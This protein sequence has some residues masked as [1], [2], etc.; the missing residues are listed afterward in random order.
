MYINIY[1]LYL[2][3]FIF[4]LFVFVFI[5]FYNIKIKRLCIQDIQVT[6]YKKKEDFFDTEGYL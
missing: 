3:Y 2:Y 5:L 4:I 1:N 6:I